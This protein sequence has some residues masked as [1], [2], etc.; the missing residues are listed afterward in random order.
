MLEPLRKPQDEPQAIVRHLVS[1]LLA[2]PLF[3]G[4]EAQ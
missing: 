1:R 2:L 3:S 4:S